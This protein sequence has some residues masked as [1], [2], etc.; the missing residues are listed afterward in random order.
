MGKTRNGRGGI[1]D[2]GATIRLFD[3]QQRQYVQLPPPASGPIVVRFTPREASGLHSVDDERGIVF[4][5]VL[6]RLL[7]WKGYQVQPQEK[8]RRDGPGTADCPA[9]ARG[10]SSC[11]DALSSDDDSRAYGEHDD[12]LCHV[13][14]GPAQAGDPCRSMW[15]HHP[16]HSR[17]TPAMLSRNGLIEDFRFAMLAAGHYRRP[18]GFWC[19]GIHSGSCFGDARTTRRRF[20]RL[21]QQAEPL[22]GTQT[23]AKAVEQMPASG[24]GRRYLTL[25]DEAISDDLHTT[26]ALHALYA[27]LRRGRL[28]NSERAVL[29]A[30]AHLFTP[31]QATNTPS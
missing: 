25:V 9:A 17:P 4:V 14:V 16:Q 3:A 23:Y 12:L 11:I 24:P 28:S 30:T 18:R 2:H 5:E 1:S 31:L 20:E 7:T 15:H 13:L 8:P 21:V 19:G 29:A 22:P 6:C 26:R 27:A 10:N